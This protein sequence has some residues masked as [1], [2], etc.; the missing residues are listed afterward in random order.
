MALARLVQNG[1]I[2]IEVSRGRTDTTACM[3]F[4]DLNAYQQMQSE[5]DTEKNAQEQKRA[6][7]QSLL[8]KGMNM[9]IAIDVARLVVCGVWALFSI[10]MILNGLT[11][12]FNTSGY[13]Q[14]SEFGMLITIANRIGLLFIWL[15]LFALHLILKSI[16][17]LDSFASLFG[18]RTDKQ[19]SVATFKET[20]ENE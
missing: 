10:L 5:T 14:G 3:R 7:E 18:G 13:V 19:A 17:E 6:K 12:W 9:K 16:T 4:I 11:T 1:N 8:M 15:A 2:Q 20:P